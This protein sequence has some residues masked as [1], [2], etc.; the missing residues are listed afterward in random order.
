LTGEG[1]DDDGCCTSGHC[2][3]GEGVMMMAAV[4]VVTA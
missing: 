3:T 4:S 1:G 2:L